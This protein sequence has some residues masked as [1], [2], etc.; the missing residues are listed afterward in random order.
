M[1]SGV[2]IFMKWNTVLLKFRIRYIILGD[3]KIKYLTY[4]KYPFEVS[5][6]LLGLDQVVYHHPLLVVF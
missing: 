5:A 6:C 2:D 3:M 4:Q 1:E